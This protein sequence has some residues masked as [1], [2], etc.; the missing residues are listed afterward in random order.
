M[1]GLRFLWDGIYGCRFPG[2][3]TSVHPEDESS[4][5]FKTST[6]LEDEH[7][8][9]PKKTYNLT[10]NAFLIHQETWYKQ[11]VQHDRL[12]YRKMVSHDWQVADW[13]ANPLYVKHLKGTKSNCIQHTIS[14]SICFTMAF[15]LCESYGIYSQ[16]YRKTWWLIF[17]TQEFLQNILKFSKWY[18]D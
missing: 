4:W 6:I 8:N 17:P 12:T 5:G 15:P 13:L 7:V 14:G 2:E 9:S 18:A 11:K 1:T 10:M 16:P 3:F